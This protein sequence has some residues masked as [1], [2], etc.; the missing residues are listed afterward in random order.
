MEDFMCLCIRENYEGPVP[1]KYVCARTDPHP[2]DF[3]SDIEGHQWVQDPEGYAVRWRAIKE[4]WDERASIPQ[5][6]LR[7]VIFDAEPDER[8]LKAVRMVPVEE[9]EDQSW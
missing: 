2:Q 5:S 1:R 8:P 7:P 9:S 3:G 4:I 6:A